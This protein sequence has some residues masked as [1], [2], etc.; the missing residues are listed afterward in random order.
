VTGL[1]LQRS[2]SHVVVLRTLSKIGLAALRVGWLTAHPLLA[3]ELEKARLPY[4]LPTYSQAAAT[5]AL[6]PLD[7]AI[8][9]HVAA[10]VQ[11]RSRLVAELARIEGVEHPRADANFVWLRVPSS[12][13]ASSPGA[14]VTEGLKARGVMVRSFAA[15]PDRIR[16]TVGSPEGDDR[17]LDGLRNVLGRV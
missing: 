10:I 15:A 4:N 11:E 5:C 13:R 6:G 17:F 16:V 12:S 9:R 2:A 1:D 14:A 7:A 3:S 8:Q